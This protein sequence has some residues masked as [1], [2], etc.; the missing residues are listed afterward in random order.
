M[1]KEKAYG[2]KMKAHLLILGKIISLSPLT[3]KLRAGDNIF[4]YHS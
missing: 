2:E 1:L 4:P 3:R